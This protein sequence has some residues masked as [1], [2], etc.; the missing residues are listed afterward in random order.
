[1]PPLLA[2]GTRTASLSPVA[3]GDHGSALPGDS[4]P[5]PPLDAPQGNH[6]RRPWIVISA[7]LAVVAAGLAVWAFSAQS[8]AD[9]A[10]AKLD[11]QAR[12]AAAATPEPTSE[13]Q[14]AELDPAT[15]QEFDQVK[16]DLGS[17]TES[18]DEIQQQLDDAAANAADADK[19]RDEASGAVDKARAELEAFKANL[20]LTRTCL[21]GALDALATSFSQ[22][23]AEA[24]VSELEKL[25][26]GCASAA[27]S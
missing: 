22:G 5:S 2:A 21:R 26:G 3:T 16:E 8:D 23:G 1:M 12:A 4:E 13:P 17:T 19:A 9:D 24:A 15:Q 14:P 11:T 18:V 20:E 10:Q 27:S 6:S 25:S 7:I